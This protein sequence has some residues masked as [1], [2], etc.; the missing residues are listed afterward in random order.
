[1]ER[2]RSLLKAEKVGTSKL[3]CAIHGPSMTANRL[4]VPHEYTCPAPLVS[5]TL[6]RDRAAGERPARSEDKGP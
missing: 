4:V 1:M 5:K 2:I 6:L 3:S